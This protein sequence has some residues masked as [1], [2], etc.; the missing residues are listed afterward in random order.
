MDRRRSAVILTKN[1]TSWAVLLSALYLLSAVAPADAVEQTDPA[2]VATDA[3]RVHG[4]VTDDARVFQGIPYAAPPVGAL[5]W[6]A[7]QPARPW[8]A[9]RE[10]TTPASPCP[11]QPNAEVPKG[12]SNEDCLYLDVTTPRR[13]SDRPR[14]VLVWMPGGGFFVGSGSSYGA[15]RLAAR[16]DVVVVTIN[17]RVGIFGFFGHAGLRDSGTFGLQDQQAALRWVQ[18]NAAAFGG[19]RS[20]VTLA[21]QSAGAMSTCAQLTSPSS[22][23]LFSKAVMQSG[24]C[25]FN[26]ASNSQYP[27]Q[28]AGSPWLPQAIVRRLGDEVG[29]QLGCQDDRDALECLR[30]L[31]A[32]KL[33]EHTLSFTSPAVGTAVLPE[34][35]AQAIQAGRFHRMAVL[36]GNNHDEA[37]SYVSA[38]NGGAIDAAGY[39]RLVSDMVGAAHAP[40]VEA[41]Y[42]SSRFDSPAIAWGAVT[43]DRIWSCTQVATDQQ[44][45]RRVPTYAYEFNDKHSPLAQFIPAPIPLG[46]AHAMELP[47][48]F[49]LGGAEYPLTP[50]QKRLSEQMIDYW[51]TFARTGNPNGPGRPHWPRLGDDASGLSLAPAGQGDIQPVDLATEHHCDFWDRLG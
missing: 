42:P 51:A 1:R 50:D 21:G 38:F 37:R 22:A 31:P 30:R 24:S 7:P 27:G 18:H 17:Y 19:D 16:G 25:A 23:G 32:A 44:L 46:A 6:R 43:T 45:A 14:P 34:D 2:V 5:R 35:P 40:K 28:E 36:S 11:Q 3:G 8:S 4:I 9:V 48:L 15:R 26:W 41:E 10:A 49:A 13:R 20:N 12:T 33:L 39:Q 47:Y 29:G